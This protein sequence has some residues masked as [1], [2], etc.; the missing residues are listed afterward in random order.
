LRFIIERITSLE[1]DSIYLYLTEENLVYLYS[2][3]LEFNDIPQ[4]HNIYLFKSNCNIDIEANKLKLINVI[5]I[6]HSFKDY[7]NNLYPDKFTINYDHFFE[8]FNKHS[9]FNAKVY[10]NEDGK[11]KNGISSKIL[12]ADLNLIN[13][14]K[15]INLINSKNFQRLWGVRKKNTIVCM[16]CEFKY[17]CVDNRLPLKSLNDKWHHEIECNYNPYISKWKNEE[18]YKSLSESGINIEKEKGIIKID[19]EKLS[20]T[21]KSIWN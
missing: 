18:G 14:T 10:I 21:F 1:V 3:F 8:S 6:T 13:E 19:E 2:T 9:Y 5:E 20:S 16:D 12:Y 7:A 17:M 11:I 15:F 4:L